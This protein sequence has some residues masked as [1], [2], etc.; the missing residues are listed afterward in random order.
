VAKKSVKVLVVGNPANTNCLITATSA[1]S[2]PKE[3]FSALTRLDH[4]RARSQVAIKAGVSVDDVHNVFIWGNHSSTQFPDLSQGLIK[5]KPAPG[6]IND[7]AWSQGEFISIV[8]KRGAAVIEKRGAS[9]A[10]SAAQAI[11]DHMYDWVHGTPEGEHISMAVP[12]DGSYGITEGIVY[13]FPVS[14]AKD[15][16]VNIVKGFDI[17]PFSREKMNVT[18]KELEEEKQVAF[19]ICGL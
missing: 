4:N 5:G 14:V 6:V 8:Q 17:P 9:S 1:P 2:I 13:S 7:E 12:S 11:V 10:F 16:K 19:A 15:G 3:N 18:L